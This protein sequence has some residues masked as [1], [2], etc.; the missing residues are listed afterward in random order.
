[1]MKHFYPYL[2]PWA[3]I[4]LFLFS[5]C[6]KEVEEVDEDAMVDKTCYSDEYEITLEQ[7][8]PLLTYFVMPDDIEEYVEEVIQDGRYIPSDSYPEYTES[9]IKDIRNLAN[10]LQKYKDGKSSYY[11]RNEVIDVLY[12]LLGNIMD[13]ENHG[14]SMC[15]NS[16]VIFPRLL[17]IAAN[18][19]PEAHELAT[20]VSNDGRFGVI[21]LSNSYNSIMKFCAIIYQNSEGVF[22]IYFLPDTFNNIEKLVPLQSKSSKEQ[23]FLLK[24]DSILVDDYIVS[25]C[26]ECGSGKINIEKRRFER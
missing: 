19:C 6:N 7:V 1:M 22:D 8:I 14:G 9:L 17:Q 16:Y 10:L 2:T 24:S 20:D 4:L 26:Q 13:I 25:Y 12:F 3:I 23:R 11:P 5:A 18:L 21:Q 15:I